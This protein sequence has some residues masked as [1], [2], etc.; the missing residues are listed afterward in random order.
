LNYR[1][2]IC[3][4]FYPNGD[5]VDTLRRARDQARSLLG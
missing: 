1:G 3:M 2:T 4:E 5:I